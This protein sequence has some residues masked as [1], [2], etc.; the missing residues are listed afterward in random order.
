MICVNCL[1]T[2]VP[3][4][5]KHDYWIYGCPVCDFETAQV[6]VADDHLSRI[7]GN[8]Y[9]T[10][11]GDGYP[12]YLAE[13]ELLTAHGRRYGHLLKKYTSPG[14]VLDVG[15]AAGFLLQ[16]LQRAGWRGIGLEPNAEMVAFGR[17]HLGLAMIAGDLEHA[18]H[19]LH[20]EQFDLIS[21]IQVI[22]H[23]HDLSK[24]LSQAAALTKPNGFWLIESWNC[25][26]LAARLLGPEWHEYSPPSVLHWFSP[27]LLAQVAAQ[28]GFHV[29]AQGRPQKWINAAHAKSLLRYKWADLPGY[30]VM[31]QAIKIVPD[32]LAL[33]YPAFDLFWM[34]LQ[35]RN[36]DNPQQQTL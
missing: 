30:A 15:A 7:Y 9:F 23:F 14:S 1:Q 29:V 31:E 34:L 17:E 33:P 16:G 26:S 11:G 24:A 2:M 5:Q 4:F 12:D 3:R 10:G 32:R 28:Y 25:R 18:T 36:H 35:K 19:K 20:D 21:M 27:D 8:H 13:G 6:D 22:G